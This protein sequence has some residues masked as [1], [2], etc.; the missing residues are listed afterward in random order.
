MNNPRN[1]LFVGAALLVIGSLLPWASVT[2]FT[3]TISVNGIDGDGKLTIAVG[4]VVGLGAFL[5]RENPGKRVSV[6]SSVFGVIAGI[7][8]LIDIVNL[9][10][11]IAQLSGNPFGRADVGIGLY[12]VIIGA[13]VCIVAGWMRWPMTSQPTAVDTSWNL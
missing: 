5:A 2:I 9:S 13:L 7:I 4:V 3:G 12:V 11:G 6:A 8:G 10:E 1:I